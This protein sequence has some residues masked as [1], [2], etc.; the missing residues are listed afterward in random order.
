MRPACPLPWAC[1][2]RRGCRCSGRPRRPPVGRHQSLVQAALLARCAPSSLV[3][4]VFPR[5]DVVKLNATR[6]IR[7]DVY[8]KTSLAAPRINARRAED[9][10]ACYDNGM[11]DCRLPAWSLRISVARRAWF[12]RPSGKRRPPGRCVKS[13]PR[14]FPFSH[15]GKTSASINRTKG[16]SCRPR[17]KTREQRGSLTRRRPSSAT[18]PRLVQDK[19]V[20]L[21]EQGAASSA[22]R[23]TSARR[24][25]A[26][27]R[28]RRER[29]AP[30]RLAVDALRPRAD[31]QQVAQLTGARGRPGRAP[32][33]LSRAGERRP[34]CCVTPRTSRG[35]VRGWSRASGSSPAWRR[36]GS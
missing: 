2:P 5:E 21:K 17:R 29:T 25:W 28:G 4:G 12:P 10:D 14:G 35:G 20:E 19:A 16:S 15:R 3:G 13:Q 23:S 9:H 1:R 31:G 30:E 22:R 36:R 8:R 18:R 32:R 34:S 26:G 6:K 33:W 27:R 11:L 7:A 24:R